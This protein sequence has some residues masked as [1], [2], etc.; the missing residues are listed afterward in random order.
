M[1]CP[2]AG[3]SSQPATLATG[4]AALKRAIQISTLG[5]ADFTVTPGLF[6]AVASARDL[7]SVVSREARDFAR[8]PPLRDVMF[9]VHQE[10]T[11]GFCE[12]VHAGDQDP[13]L[14]RMFIREDRGLSTAS[15]PASRAASA[16]A[17]SRCVINL[18]DIRQ[19]LTY[20]V[21]T[22]TLPF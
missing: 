17:T 1:S 21:V 16:S 20:T 3:Y 8:A 14:G 6:R 15:A 12:A 5:S 13:D 18:S 10:G 7:L 9:S 11:V 4:P 22:K 19:R 2:Q